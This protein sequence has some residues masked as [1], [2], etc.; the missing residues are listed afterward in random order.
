MQAA[1]IEAPSHFTDH[2]GTVHKF[3]EFWGGIVPG[4][5]SSHSSISNGFQVFL[6]IDN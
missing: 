4:S 1:S 2:I 3:R 5:T 6:K